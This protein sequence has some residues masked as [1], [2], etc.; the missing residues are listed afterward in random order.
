NTTDLETCQGG[1][2]MYASRG[3]LGP[4]LRLG[5]HARRLRFPW[6]VDD[7]WHETSKQSFGAC[8]PKLSLGTRGDGRDSVLIFGLRAFEVFEVFFAE[9][10]VMGKLV[11]HRRA[12]VA[13]ESPPRAAHLFHRPA[14]DS[15]DVGVMLAVFLVCERHPREQSEQQRFSLVGFLAVFDV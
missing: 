4:K 3:I 14:K 2:K 12:D 6:S 7:T 10:E 1:L 11:D 15:H 13:D 5:P 8:V 9:A